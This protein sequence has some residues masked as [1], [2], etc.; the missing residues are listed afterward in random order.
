MNRLIVMC[1]LFATTIVA[2][3]TLT[4]PR[5]EQGDRPDALRQFRWDGTRGVVIVGTDVVKSTF[6]PIRSY[7]HTGERRG[8]EINIFKDFPGLDH[9]VVEDAAAGPYETTVL[10]AV[11][12]FGNN[13]LRHVILTYAGDGTLKSIV[14]TAPYFTQAIAVDDDGTII[15]IA[16]RMDGSKAASPYP[17]LLTYSPSGELLHQ[18]F[19]SSELNGGDL[20][21]GPDGQSV[22]RVALVDGQVRFYAPVARQIVTCTRDGNVVQKIDLRPILAQAKVDDKM[23]RI[24]IDDVVLGPT[25]T[26]LSMAEST[27]D[28]TRVVFTIRSLDLETSRTQLLNSASQRN[29]QLLG[30]YG[31]DYLTL[32][33]GAVPALKSSPIATP[34]V[35]R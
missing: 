16:N 27:S 3:Q 14:D 19:P 10:A 29:V 7:T 18:A 20:G 34:A 32:Q 22:A 21:V 30:V 8:A 31:A 11:L 6:P 28:R 4:S 1:V 33:R 17:L 15:T 9:A 13:Q 24:T 35:R 5:R 23:D 2:A 25:R 26:L 12:N